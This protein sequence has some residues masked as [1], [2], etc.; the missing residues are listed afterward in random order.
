M[1]VAAA[2]TF[3]KS[4]SQFHNFKNLQIKELGETT[5][6]EVSMAVTLSS[7]QCLTPHYS[8]K[9]NHLLVSQV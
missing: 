5:G 6:D 7:S 4:V 3:A 8:P 2:V 1:A 9:H